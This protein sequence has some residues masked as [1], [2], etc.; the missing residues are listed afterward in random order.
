ME[1]RSAMLPKLV[2]FDCDGV[3]VDSEILANQVFLDKLTALGLELNLADLFERFVGRTMADC[4]AQV[5]VMLGKP[6]P[7]QF[8]TELDRATFQAFENEL[9]AVEGIGLVLDTLDMA[10]IPYCV[11]S[12]GSHTKMNKTLGLT[13]LLPRLEGRIFSATEVAR[14]KPFP[15]I[16][17]H[18]AHQMHTA[19]QD[20]VVIE[21]SPTGA[22]A[23]KAAGMKVF[24]Y[25][26]TLSSQSKLKDT[27]AEVFED[28]HSLP[29]LLGIA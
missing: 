20:C 19:P 17:L 16:Y 10:K 24:G 1:G 23:G 5:E 6:A 15:D 3:L 21:D 22:R 26:A 18:A 9:K 4:M 11:A 12:S 28:M 29:R 25:G 14:P 27:G 8:V 2:I 7:A 13:G